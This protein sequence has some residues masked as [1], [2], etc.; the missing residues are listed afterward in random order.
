MKKKG[1]R[2]GFLTGV[3]CCAILV[4]LSISA[5]AAT[6]TIV[7]NDDIHVTIDG[8]AFV[9]KDA[10]GNQVPL[11]TCEGTTYAPIRA[12]CEAIG[13][14]VDYDAASNTAVIKTP[15]KPAQ[16]AGPGAAEEYITADRAKEIALAHAGAAAGADFIRT[17]LDFD[18]GRW[19]YEVEFYAG[20]TEYDYEIDAVTGEIL[21]FDHDVEGF[22]IPSA[23]GTADGYITADRA[24]EIALA[25]APGDSTVVKCKLDFDDGRAVYELELRSG[26]VE[27][28]CEIDAVTGAVL[29]WEIDD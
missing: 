15:E 23:G 7:I 11:F 10:N 2:A 8:A 1:F 26:R 27:Y 19:E 22:Q 13:L 14:S 20:S 4:C 21:S 9:P 12:I 6:R 18:G 29:S 24:K 17:E 28:E 5:L 25:R 16:S 3:V